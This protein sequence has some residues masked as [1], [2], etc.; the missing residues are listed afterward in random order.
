MKLGHFYYLPCF[1]FCSVDT[2]A[3]D[4]V[5]I[6]D[7]KFKHFVDSK[8]FFVKDCAVPGMCFTRKPPNKNPCI[9]KERALE[10]DT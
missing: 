8:N 1:V 7:T 6:D 2:K 9:G 10:I 5:C 3:N 4:F